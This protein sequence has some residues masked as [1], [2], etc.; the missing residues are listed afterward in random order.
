MEENDFIALSAF[1]WFTLR[2]L[3]T[4]PWRSSYGQVHVL[5]NFPLETR[6]R[7]TLDDVSP[8]LATQPG[9]SPPV[10]CVHK[11]HCGNPSAHCFPNG[12]CFAQSTDLRVQV[13]ACISAGFQLWGSGP[14]SLPAAAASKPPILRRTQVVQA[15]SNRRTLKALSLF[16]LLSFSQPHRLGDPIPTGGLIVRS[17]PIYRP[18]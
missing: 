4:S 11:S 18:Q 6:P 2:D 7:D 13:L 14:S 16:I 8:I 3:A 10:D 12:A 9:A 15:L 1:P 5:N 17:S